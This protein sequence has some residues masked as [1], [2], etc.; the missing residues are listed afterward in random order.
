[1]KILKMVTAGVVGLS[2]SASGTCGEYI[3]QVKAQLTLIQLAAS[4][5]GWRKHIMLSLT[6]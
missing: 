1:M 3:D 2:I 6:N 4:S 5:E